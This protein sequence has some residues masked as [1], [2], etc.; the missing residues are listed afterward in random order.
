MKSS[1]KK[2]HLAANMVRAADRALL[3]C[4]PAEHD[5]DWEWARR[6]VM[7]AVAHIEACERR[8]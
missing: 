2:I 1:L 8:A 4:E 7:E 6:K 5:V 3:D